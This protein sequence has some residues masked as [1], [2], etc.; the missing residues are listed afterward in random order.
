VWDEKTLHAY[1]SN[2]SQ[3]LPR[4]KKPTAFRDATQ[5]NRIIKYLKATQPVAVPE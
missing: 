4:T 2:P 1:L 5:L 3:Y